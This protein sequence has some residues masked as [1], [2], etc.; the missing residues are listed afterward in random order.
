MGDSADWMEDKA[1]A[2]RKG[3]DSV[4]IDLF[5]IP[6]NAVEMVKA[7]SPGLEVTEEDIEFVTLHS[8]LMV[9]PYND[10]GLL[11]KDKMFFCSEAQSTWSLNVLVRMFLYLAETYNRY[12]QNHKE[13]NIYGTKKITIPKPACFVIYT[14]DKKNLPEFLHLAE[15][16]FAGD[17]ALDLKVKV[18]ATPGTTDI[19][20]QYIRFCHLFDEQVKVHGKTKLAI[21]ET[22]RLCRD[23]NVLAKYLAESEGEDLLCI[24]DGIQLPHEGVRSGGGRYGR[25]RPPY[26]RDAPRPEGPAAVREGREP[27]SRGRA[28][29]GLRLHL[30]AQRP[31]PLREL[32]GRRSLPAPRRKAVPEG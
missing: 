29:G 20:Q 2:R 4:F 28:Q 5:H 15:E 22:I 8:V 19:V 31:R 32:R 3:K 24:R 18:L 26:E 30:Q 16:F 13:M 9:R 17:S 1:N 11:V 25:V 14:G 10:L 7:F 23:E 6:A 27:R 12:I 21:E